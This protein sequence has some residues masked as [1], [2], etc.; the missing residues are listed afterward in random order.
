MGETSRLQG[1]R[2]FPLKRGGTFILQSGPNFPFAKW[3]E[4]LAYNV[5]GASRLQ[6]GRN[7][8]FTIWAVGIENCLQSGR[9]FEF[10]MW[11]GIPVYN[12]G[13]ASRIKSERNFAPF[14]AANDTEVH[15]RQNG[16]SLVYS[17]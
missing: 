14:K 11:A 13:G 2:R 8:P 16:R 3:A 10:T 7:I 6:C 17:L 5:G 9:S 12:L 1:G 4:H 15:V